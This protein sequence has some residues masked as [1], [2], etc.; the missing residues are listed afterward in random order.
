MKLNRYPDGTTYVELDWELLGGSTIEVIFRMNSYEDLWILVQYCE[1][2]SYNGIEATITIPNLLE[3]QADRRFSKSQSSSLHIIAH[4]LNNFDNIF[5]KIFHPHNPEVVEALFDCVEIISNKVFIEEVIDI[6]DSPNLILMS[7]DAGGFKPLMKLADEINWDG[8]VSSC[9]K[10]RFW[11]GE[12]SILTQRVDRED[13]EGKD[14]LIVDDIC[15]YGGTFKGIS[16]L[17]KE[18]NCGKIYLAV[19]HMTVQKQLDPI[20]DYFDKMF[21][22]NS[23]YN[24]YIEIGKEEIEPN[25]LIILNYE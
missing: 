4:L 21:V 13:F 2:L 19:S 23:K 12:K 14:I 6:I 7:T 16:K 18:K 25:N 1:A 3:A 9:S 20:W 11:N 22:T 8:E 24:N 5:F 10:G 17:L 15:I